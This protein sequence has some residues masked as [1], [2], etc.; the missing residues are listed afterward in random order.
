MR[1]ELRKTPRTTKK[2]EIS[3]HKKASDRASK[4]PDEPFAGTILDL[5]VGG[6]GLLVESPHSINDL[7]SLKDHPELN[8]QQNCVVRW[9]RKL[10]KDYHLGVQFL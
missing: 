2:L 7:L 8:A 5:G 6:A 1:I 4:C 9:V 10:S 3:Y